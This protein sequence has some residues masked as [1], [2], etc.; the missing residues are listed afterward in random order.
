[1]EEKF[2]EW[3]RNKW[4]NEKREYRRKKK[5]QSNPSKETI[6]GEKE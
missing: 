3:Q 5:L 2:V 1:M 4:K 6:K